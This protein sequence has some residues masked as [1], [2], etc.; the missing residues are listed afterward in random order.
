MTG[1][2]TIGRCLPPESG[3]VCTLFY[4]LTSH[5]IDRDDCSLDREH[6]EKS[7]DRR[8]LIGLFRHFHLAQHQTLAR[9]EGG[10]HVD[11]A[12][13]GLAAGTARGLAVNRHDTGGHPGHRGG[14][15]H[16]TLLELH[17]VQGGEDIAEMVVRLRTVREGP[18]TAEEVELLL[19]EPGDIGE[20]IGARQYREQGQQQHFGEW[21]R[22]LA[23]LPCIGQVIEMM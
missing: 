14:P 18:E 10:H 5:R 23:A 19:A 9:G 1:V 6:F 20:G 2:E 15:G 22:D 8:D 16:E 7:G 4:T 17:R 11:G 3:K 21:I 13:T 12:F